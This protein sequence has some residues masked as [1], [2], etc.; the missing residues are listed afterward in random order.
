ML[1]ST[2]AKIIEQLGVSEEQIQKAASTGQDVAIPLSKY[3]AVM[4]QHVDIAEKLKA[5]TKTEE[6]G[7]T[8]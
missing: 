4:S 8:P 2:N 1:Q 5:Y 3:Q 7:L 6:D